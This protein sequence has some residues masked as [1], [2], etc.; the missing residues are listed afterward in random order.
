M[1]CIAILGGTF[2]PVHNAHLAMGQAALA[3]LRPGRML[4]IPTGDPP[5]RSAPVAKAAH[6]VGMLRV[7]LAGEPRH[8]ID[9]RELA[10]GASGY[11]FDTVSALRLETSAELVLLMGAD[12]YAALE[13]WYRW[14]ELRA[15][16]RIAVFARPG[17]S[18]P[19]G[20]AQVIPMAPMRVSASA[21]RARLAAGQDVSGLLP[22]AVL[23]Y[24]KAN[25]LYH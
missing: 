4:W 19:G 11:S 5:Y 21:I 25:G 7:A 9:E 22:A 3:A 20:D 13:T 16:A 18:P 2:D 23:A 12:Q 10:S 14:R 17:A 24:I 6:R 15:L 1:A 8:A